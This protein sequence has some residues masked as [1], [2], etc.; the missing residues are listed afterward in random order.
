MHITRK[1]LLS[2]VLAACLTLTM[3][4]W[5]AAESPYAPCSYETAGKGD[6]GDVAVT[7]VI[8]ENGI[9][10]VTVGDNSET[11][12]IGTWAIEEMGSSM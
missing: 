2:F 8:D 9:V 12:G 3:F 4:A 10:S 11:E 1:R 7:T 6:G 5:W